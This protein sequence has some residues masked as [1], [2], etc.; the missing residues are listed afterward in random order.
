MPVNAPPAATGAARAGLRQRLS[1]ALLLRRSHL[2]IGLFLTPWLAMYAVS[3]VVFNHWQLFN[4]SAQPFQRERE[5]AY[6]PTFAPDATLR[7]KGERI[8]EDLHLS[9]SFGIQQRADR[10]IIDR[11]D[12][13]TPRRI[14]YFPGQRK[15]LLERQAFRAANWLTTLHSQVGYTNKLKRIKAWA[16]TVDLTAVATLLLTFSGFWMWWELKV[17]RRWGLFFAL[18][19]VAL[20]GI[21][22]RY[23]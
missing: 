8:L 1:F 12:P 9:G 4:H 21:F 13:V 3:T 22:L 2:Y 18:F 11:R 20:F 19:G 10:V 7:A 17:T 6:D 5:V 15:L 14:T 16:F 23:A